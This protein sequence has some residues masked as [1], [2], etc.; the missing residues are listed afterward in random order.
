MIRVLNEKL[1][2]LVGRTD[3]SLDKSLQQRGREARDGAGTTHK[4]Y[5]GD[6]ARDQEHPDRQAIAEVVWRRAGDAGVSSGSYHPGVL[7][8]SRVGVVRW[9]DGLIASS[10][11]SSPSPRCP[12]VGLTWMG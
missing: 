2:I 10:T 8:F 6:E 1:C 9:A 4:P 11:A 7:S 3:G 12:A 5:P